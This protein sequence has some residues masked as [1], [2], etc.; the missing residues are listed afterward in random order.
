[1]SDKRL[2]HKIWSEKHVRFTMRVP[3]DF[4]HEVRRLKKEL[5]VSSLSAVFMIAVRKL[6]KDLQ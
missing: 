2:A 6:H 4:M 3:H 1:M 5:R